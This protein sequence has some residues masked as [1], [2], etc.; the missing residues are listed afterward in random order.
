VTVSYSHELE[1]VASVCTERDSDIICGTSQSE[2]AETS[3]DDA[4]SFNVYNSD[5]DVT[6]SK[7]ELKLSYCI[8]LL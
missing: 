3:T 2:D 1:I 8:L 6:V 5:H 4:I 7:V